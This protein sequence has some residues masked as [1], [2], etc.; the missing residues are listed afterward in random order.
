MPVVTTLHT[1]LRDPDPVQREVMDQLIARSSRL[2]VM[3]R[4][5]AEILQSVYAAP[6]A[7]VVI[8]PHGIPDI[9][10]LDSG[11]FKPQFGLAGRKVL[12]TFGLLGP[13]KG[14]ENVIEALP[15]IV[16]QHPDVVYVILGATHPHLV[17]QEGERY[18]EGLVKLAGELG[19]LGHVIFHDRFV[20]LDD[21][22]EFIGATDVYVTPY[23]NEAQITSG[24]LAYVFGAG[25]AVVSTPYWH[26][27]ELLADGRGVLV[28]F[29]DPGAIAAGVLSYL[30]DPELMRTTRD[31]A[32]LMGREMIWSA[33]GRSYVETL[34]RA[35]TERK[36]PVRPKPPMVLTPKGR[37]RVYAPLDGAAA[38]H[39]TA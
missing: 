31:R 32:W 22:K 2:V 5:G 3:A 35:F 37:N 13:G 14:I 30:D 15:E 6:R 33:V 10:K 21:L 8:I 1:I 19:V 25:K 20:P 4:K 16:R 28:P 34:R 23:L 17:A 7:K 11:S 12:L 26:A 18:R 29:R 27:Q 9:P 36:A 38:Q 24:T 39:G